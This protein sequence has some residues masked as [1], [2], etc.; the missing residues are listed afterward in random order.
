MSGQNVRRLALDALVRAERGG[1]YLN[2]ELDSALSRANLAPADRALF[3]ALV[4]GVCERALTLDHEI[5]ILSDRSADKFDIETRASLRLGLFQILFLDK[6]P[7]HAA[8]NETV[9]A[10]PARSRGLVNAVLRR[11]IR[12]GSRLHLPPDDGSA[13]Y[14]SLANSVPLY[15]VNGWLRDY[16]SLA[17]Q[18]AESANRRPP[19]TLRVNTLRTSASALLDRFCR[20]GIEANI[21]SHFD[22][23]IDVFRASAVNSIPGY[24][25]GLWFVED[26][27]SRAAV[28]AAHPLPGDTVADVCAAPGGKSFSAAIDMENRGRIYSFDIHENKLSLIL[29]GAS[30]LGLDIISAAVRDGRDP[31]P[32]LRS[33]FDVVICDAPCS[34]LGVI[35]KK[36]DIR[37]KDMAAAARLPEVQLALLSA[38]AEYVKPGG[39]LLYSTCTLV[40]AENEGVAA[41]FLR[42]HEDFEPQPFSVC[43]ENAV[44]GMLTLTPPK[45]GTDGFFIAKFKKTTSK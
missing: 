33:L 39:T 41:G 44:G 29:A 45:H 31:D 25:E 32:A 7:P 4:Y 13:E 42:G 17:R 10:A 35:A 2:L 6:I 5:L 22:D 34:G 11:E 26:A 28:F 15:I 1:K 19:V 36:P 24:D 37:Y 18:L 12:E 20:D 3:T 27:A 8:V 9:S 23:M 40:R 30:R 14:L 16:G 21:N 43:G 38:A